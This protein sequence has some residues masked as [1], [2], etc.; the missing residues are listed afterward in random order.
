M[1]YCFHYAL[2]NISSN[3]TTGADGNRRCTCLYHFFFIVFKTAEL[4]RVGVKRPWFALFLLLWSRVPTIGFF[5]SCKRFELACAVEPFHYDGLEGRQ[6]AQQARNVVTL[7]RKNFEAKVTRPLRVIAHGGL[8]AA[9]KDKLLCN[10]VCVGGESNF[11]AH[12][13]PGAPPALSVLLP[14]YMFNNSYAQWGCG[15]SLIAPHVDVVPLRPIA[16]MIKF[17]LVTMA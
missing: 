14:V 4:G 1:I 5:R 15:R 11:A 2:A 3:I 16:K 8:H 6:P 7:M 10:R 17:E 9:D 13:L 12:L